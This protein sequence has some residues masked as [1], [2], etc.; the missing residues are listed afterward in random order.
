MA[1]ILNLQGLQAPAQE[2]IGRCSSFSGQDC[3]NRTRVLT[4]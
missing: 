2:Y 1:T 3:C 4:E